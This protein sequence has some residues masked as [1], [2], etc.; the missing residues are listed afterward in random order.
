MGDKNITSEDLMNFLE[1]FK[2]SMEVRMDKNKGSMEVMIEDKLV[3]IGKKIDVRFDDIDGEIKNLKD[4]SV[5]AEDAAVRMDRRLKNLEM[6]MN[7]TIMSSRRREILK[8]T[9][10][11]ETDPKIQPEGRSDTTRQTRA[12]KEKQQQAWKELEGNPKENYQSEWARTMSKEL[13]EAAIAGDSRRDMREKTVPDI[14]PMGRPR[15]EMTVKDKMSDNRDNRD[16][17]DIRDIRDIRDKPVPDRWEQLIPKTSKPKV[18]KPP[19]ITQWFGIDTDT[20]TTEDTDENNEWSEVENRKRNEIKKKNQRKKKKDLEESTSRK[21]ANMIGIGPINLDK[22]MNYKN[23]NKTYENMKIEVIK[24]FLATELAY[25]PDELEELIICETKLAT[26]GEN[27]IYLALEN[28]E[29]VKEIHLRKAELKN[30]TINTRNF[31]PPNFYE[32]FIYLNKICKEERMR[33]P[34]MKTQLR[35][36]NKNI[37]IFVKYKGDN[38]PFKKIPISDLTDPDL[39]PGFNHSIHWKRHIDRPPRRTLRKTNEDETP[40][41]RKDTLRRQ[42]SESDP[43]QNKKSKRSSQSSDSSSSDT[44]QESPES[45]ATRNESDQ[46]MTDTSRDPDAT[47]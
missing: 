31:I 47:L 25:E 4:K 32:R 17:E 11:P 10:N 43:S 3:K 41:S 42:H 2:T 16:Y 19:K 20:D 23:E 27:I 24:D 21:A 22:L 6:E 34:D 30:D 13:S 18:R 46:E 26:N 35:F 36:G 5:I 1:K 14:Q 28:Y 29:Q 38:A 37:E 40:A 8:D 45:P 12:E 15:K 7:K 9:L 39:V 33:N 44:E